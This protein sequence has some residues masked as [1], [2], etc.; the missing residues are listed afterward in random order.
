MGAEFEMTSTKTMTT[1]KRL[2]STAFELEPN[3]FEQSFSRTSG[4]SKNNSD[5]KNK[6]NQSNSD[7]IKVDDKQDRDKDKID[8]SPKP[9][10]P[11]LASIASPDD[12]QS[13]SSWALSANAISNHNSLRAGPLSPAMLSGPQ[14]NIDH[15]TFRTGLTPATGLTPLVAG[16]NGFPP[17]SPNTAAFLAM[18]AGAN[19]AG[20]PT[21]NT[22][23]SL[24]AGAPNPSGNYSTS[25]NGT[26]VCHLVRL[27]SLILKCRSVLCCHRCRRRRQRS[28]PLISGSS[29]AHETRGSPSTRWCRQRW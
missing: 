11:P 16:G 21:P 12:G 10:L 9:T 15:S 7:S 23:A 24:A 26:Q 3:P 19:S 17:A 6:L 13:Y 8:D 2:K 20:L 25:Q 27:F 22:L 4:S 1:T 28:L 29:G 18:V 5:F 14:H